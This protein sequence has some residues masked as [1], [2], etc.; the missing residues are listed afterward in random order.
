[1]VQIIQPVVGCLTGLNQ[2]LKKSIK[3]C[4]ILDQGVMDFS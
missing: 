1:M 3:V 2:N 4:C